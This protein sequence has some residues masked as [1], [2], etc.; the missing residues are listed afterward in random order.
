M[1]SWLMS[2]FRSAAGAMP[3]RLLRLL[4]LLQGRPRWSAAELTE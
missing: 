3:A 1:D 2:R 4:T